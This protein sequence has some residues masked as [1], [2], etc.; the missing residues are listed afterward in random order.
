MRI[1]KLN[2]YKIYSMKI[3][4]LFYEIKLNTLT[5][6]ETIKILNRLEMTL[7]V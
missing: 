3:N 4:Y 2:T 5:V 1:D 7:S 6:N